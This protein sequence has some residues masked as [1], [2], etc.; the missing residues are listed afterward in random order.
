MIENTEKYN[1][2]APAEYSK[3]AIGRDRRDDRYDN[4][5]KRRSRSRTPGMNYLFKIF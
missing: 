1:R 4:R 3:E 2:D 5:E